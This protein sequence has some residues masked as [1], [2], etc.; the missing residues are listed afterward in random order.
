MA[1]A[2]A[3]PVVTSRSVGLIGTGVVGSRAAVTIARSGSIGSLLVNDQRRVAVASA[4][5]TLG[6]RADAAPAD[7]VAAQDVVVLASGRG[8]VDAARDIVVRGGRCVT[9]TDSVGETRALLELDSIAADRGAVLVV[10]ATLMPG[11]SG[12]IARALCERLDEADEIHVAVD[13]TG[14]PACARQHHRALGGMAAAAWHDGAWIERPAGSGRELLWFPEP[15]GPQDCYRAE[16]PEPY[17]L[18]QAFPSVERISARMSAT[19][20]DRLTARLPMLSPP[21]RQG[22]VGALRVEVRGHVAGERRAE[23]L[24][25]AE[26]PGTAAGIVAGVVAVALA[27]GL[28]DQPGVHVLGEAG[29][30]NGVLLDRVRSAGLRL[31]EYVGSY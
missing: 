14:G 11:A 26:R 22:G 30:P 5:R 13:G 24:G 16:V 1:G 23:V 27:D 6:A 18:H 12:L 31:H 25:V 21:H 3:E 15:V 9:T 20:R 7:I 17:L 8:Q 19:R 29:M 28:I 2:P 4:L 10:G